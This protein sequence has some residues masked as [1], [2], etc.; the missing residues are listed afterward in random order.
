MFDG[1][2]VVPRRKRSPRRGFASDGPFRMP[3]AG[4]R[5]AQDYQ[6]KIPA[7]R[8]GHAPIPARTAALARCGRFKA[9]N[10]SA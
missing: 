5:R 7:G 2:A 6:D 9:R 10:D 8:L 4:A 3:D 1:C